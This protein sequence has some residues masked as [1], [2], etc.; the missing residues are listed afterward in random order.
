MSVSSKL[1]DGNELL[2]KLRVD[3]IL[4]FIKTLGAPT[5]MTIFHLRA[6]S[7]I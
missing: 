5:K 1:S 4:V 3:L 2:L 7:L 6:I